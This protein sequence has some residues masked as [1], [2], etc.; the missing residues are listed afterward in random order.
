[1]NLDRQSPITEAELYGSI[2]AFIVFA[3]VLSV[4]LIL[5]S[6]QDLFS[7]SKLGL[8]GAASLFWGCLSILAFK[9]F[10]DIY[11]KYIYPGWLRRLGSFNFILYGLIAWGIWLILRVSTFNSLLL[12]LFLGG[13]EGV[14]EHIIGIYGLDVLTKVPWLHGLKTFPILLFSFVE[15]IVYWSLVLWLTLGIRA[16]FQV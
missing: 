13:M 7:G 11:Y 15:Y 1:M 2:L 16:L 8:V 4:P 3:I 9:Y 6:P 5:L 10:W 14:V 12:F